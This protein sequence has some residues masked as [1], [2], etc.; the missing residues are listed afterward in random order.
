MVGCSKKLESNH[1]TVQRIIELF[2]LPPNC[3]QFRGDLAKSITDTQMNIEN[4]F[5]RKLLYKVER[6]EQ[7][8]LTAD[9][10]P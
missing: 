1:E 4:R 6:Y 9:M 7:Y 5:S 10:D 2:D 8:Q 3:V